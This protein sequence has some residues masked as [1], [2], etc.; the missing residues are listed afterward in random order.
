[1]A[2]FEFYTAGRIIYGRGEFA[3]IGELT[4]SLGHK[5]MVVMGRH[6]RKTDLIDQLAA[7]LD[8]YKIARAYYVVEGEPEISTVEEALHEAR[9]GGCDMVIG[10]GGGSAI[11]TAKAVSGLLTNGGTALDYM[12]VVGLGKSLTKPAAPLIAVPTTAGTGTEVTRNAVIGYKEKAFKASIRSPYLLPRVALV[13]PAL[14][15]SMPPEITA[16]TGL[17]ALTQLIEPYVSNRAQPL[18]DGMALTGIRMVARSLRRAYRDGED[19]AARDDMALAALMG[20]ICLANAGLGAVHGFASPLG[21][22]FPIPHGV[23]CAALLPHVMA[24]NVAA[25]RAQDPTSPTLTRYADIGE[26]LL[27]RR[28]STDEAT[29][30]A[31][32]A[33]VEEL[34]Q[35]LRIPRL[36]QFGLTEAH[37]PDLIERAKQASSMRY[38]PVT[39]SDEALVE[40]LRR[41]L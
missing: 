33:F 1:M 19:A 4:A 35:E 9:D 25:L 27:G 2:R 14:T 30:E 26:A 10:L 17:D 24:A 36:S 3:R 22:A 5:A 41:A 6:V 37:I 13:D 16:S 8:S 21:A 29:I 34:V 38:N 28:L 32:I 40:V 18:T 7:L 31:G 11:D 23:I 39:L 15:H 20:G 12:E